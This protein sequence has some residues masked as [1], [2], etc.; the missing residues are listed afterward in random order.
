MAN[1]SY[2]NLDEFGRTK[3]VKTLAQIVAEE[4]A[5]IERISFKPVAN[6]NTSSGSG[7]S[8]SYGYGVA[9]AFRPAPLPPRGAPL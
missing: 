8:A 7:S 4:N 3:S 9:P 2:V 6:P 5:G 1:N